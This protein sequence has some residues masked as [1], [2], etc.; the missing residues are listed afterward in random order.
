LSGRLVVPADNERNLSFKFDFIKINQSSTGSKDSFLSL[1][2]GIKDEFD[3][4]ADAIF[5]NGKNYG[6][7]EFSILPEDNKL[8]LYDIKGIY[9]KWGLKNTNE[10]VSSLQIFKNTIGW[11]SNLKTKIY[12]GSPEK[13]MT[14]IGIKP[15][16]ELD[17]L[18]LDTDLTWNNLPWLFDYNLIKG[19]FTTNLDGLT[20]KNSND[21][22]TSNNLLRLVN[23]FNIADSFEKV[24]N[25]DFRKLYK[26]GFSAD[27]VTGKFRITD[28]SVKIKEPVLLKS[29]SSQFSWTGDISRDQKGNLDKL[30]LEVIM[31]LPLREY[32][33]A[34]ALV[35]GGPMT[36]GVVYIAGKA[37]ERNLD[38][39]SSG[40]WTIKGS[41]SAPRTE[42]D[43][44]FEDNTD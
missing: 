40:K 25:L 37:F 8:T 1:Y 32:L 2:N 36:A 41:I 31:T 21:L 16:F 33:P 30:N 17:T 11:T 5:L 20:I 35:L 42:F 27:T 43:G 34:Y 13:A 26:R 14:Q 29:G 4:R 19:E 10:G 23:I 3:F 9:G 7:W 24:T 6:N 12:S 18:S 15:N 44:W 22:E 38:K 39:L 28:K